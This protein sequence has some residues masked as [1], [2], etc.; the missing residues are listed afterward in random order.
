MAKLKGPLF[1]LAASGKLADTLVY[2]AW[3]GLKVARQYVIPAN[4]KTSAQ[5]AQ[6]G[7]LTEA[8][9]KIHT[10]QAQAANPLDE[11]DE[12]AYSRWGSI[13]ASPRTWFNQICKAWIDCRVATKIPVIYSDGTI[14]DPTPDSISLIMY[15]NEKTAS[16][17][18]A[19]K[20]YF[21]DT[22]SSLI[23]SKAATVVAGV[24]VALTTADCSAFL[25]TGV[26]AYVQFRPDAG[27]GCEGAY[28]GIYTF[29][30]D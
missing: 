8:V 5:T 2:F 11:D 21:G 30:P 10:V 27:D 1:S 25:T 20:F 22:P 6:R 3:K 15:L 17:L 12:V 23:N 19:G 7:Y 13:F 24:S 16:T 14:S 18:A 29:M 9:A 4:P 26:R 28:S